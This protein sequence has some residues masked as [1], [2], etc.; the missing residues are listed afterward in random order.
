MTTTAIPLL[1]VARRQ[2]E[3]WQTKTPERSQVISKATAPQ[4]HS[5]LAIISPF[6]A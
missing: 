1:P 5:P 2:I 3:Q 4:L 6:A